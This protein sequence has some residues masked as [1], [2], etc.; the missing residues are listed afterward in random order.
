MKAEKLMIGDLVIHGFGH[1][2]KIT[3]IDTKTVVIKDNGF[4]TG[5]GMNEVSFAINELTPIPLTPEILEQNGFDVSDKEVMQ[6]HF[7][8]D[9]EKYHFSLRQMYDKDGKPHGFSFNAFNVL[10]LIDY[11]HELQHALRLCGIDKEITI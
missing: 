10:T 7:E 1:I 9:G 5:D 8:E 6:Y 4:D 11:V 3:E 2:G